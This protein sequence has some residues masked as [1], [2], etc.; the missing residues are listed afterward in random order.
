V[1]GRTFFR[2]NE[3][4]SGDARR[5]HDRTARFKVTAR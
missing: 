2:A 4:S 3:F 1:T 5:R